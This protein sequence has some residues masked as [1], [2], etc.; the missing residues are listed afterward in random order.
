LARWFR[1][2]LH[3]WAS[4][5]FESGILERVGIRTEGVRELF[6]EHRRRQADH[7]RALWTLLVLSEW[8][9]WVEHETR[10]PALEEP[11]GADPAELVPAPEVQPGVTAGCDTRIA[12]PV[13]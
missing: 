5:R 9:D 10:P 13:S 3:D 11:R 6:S 2:P 8:L 1:G 4:N 7:A 12:A